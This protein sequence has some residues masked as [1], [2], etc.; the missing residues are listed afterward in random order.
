ML[1]DSSKVYCGKSYGNM[2]ICENYPEC[3]SY[4]GVHKGTNKPL[5]IMANAE[6]RELK[7]KCH[8]QFDVLWK[9]GAMSRR[10]AY[11]KLQ[12]IM[13]LPQQEAHIGM[14]TMSQCRQLLTKLETHEEFKKIR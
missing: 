13:N 12:K 10:T 6:H 1:E 5:G 14:F 11:S 9:S 3:D 2:Y 4:V 7:K 8:A